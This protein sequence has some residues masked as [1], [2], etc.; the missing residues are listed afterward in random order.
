VAD[1]KRAQRFHDEGDTK[2]LRGAFQRDRDRILYTTAF[3]RLAEVTQTVSPDEGHVFHNRLTHSM[4]VAQV[5]RR[6]AERL[7]IEQ[8]DLA[9]VLGV[10]PD[11]AETA[12]LAHD[13]GH[14]PFG[15]L[16]E[17][18][19]DAEVIKVNP[20]GYEGNA[21]SFRIVTKLALKDVHF[22]GL[23]LTRATLNGLLKYPWRRATGGNQAKKWGAYHTESQEFDWAREGVEPTSIARTAEAEIMDWAD[24]ITYAIH[25]ASDFYIAGRIPFERLGSMKDDSERRRFC[26][27]DSFKRAAAEM[28]FA[29]TDLES[30][31]EKLIQYL[32]FPDRYDGTRLQRGALRSA[33]STLI[34]RFVGAIALRTPDASNRSCVEIE[35][36]SRKQVTML[37]QLTWHYVILNDRL[38]TQQ[39]GQ[40]KLIRD[41]FQFHR[42]AVKAG[43]LQLFPAP[44]REELL[45]DH[46]H[47]SR[48]IA[49]YI[50]SMT[51]KQALK[52]Y[53]RLAGIAPG[54][55]LH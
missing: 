48:V 45:A 9:N 18:Q 27:G 30:D 35:P 4:K 5:A 33:C 38:G 13:L 7:L 51:E 53:L 26:D 52:L 17:E 47:H 14:P 42:E 2:D 40:R 49:D 31:F 3:Q 21:Q 46:V 55:S 34:A 36:E 6:I 8:P 22:P 44:Y 11:V 24:D 28:G 29:K 54:S 37:K 32:P 1:E 15:H 43:N 20:D 12:A 10:D 39:H 25:D 23:N 50:A 19:L 41:L 16:A